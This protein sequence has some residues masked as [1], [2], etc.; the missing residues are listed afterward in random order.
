MSEGAAVVCLAATPADRAAIVALLRACDL[1]TADLPSSLEHFFVGQAGDRIVGVIGL[2][3]H[4]NRGLVRSLAVAPGHRGQR[5]ARALWHAALG[6][7]RDL[8][9]GDLF[10]LTATAEA[11][12]AHWG[13]VRVAREAAPDEIR[14]TEQFRSL[15]PA[16]AAVMRLAV[17]EAHE[18]LR[19]SS[20]LSV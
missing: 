19:P 14:Q 16:S 6:R 7:A 3:V 10:L 9:L 12:F 1:P 18:F 15:C 20:R 8:G 5:L 2:E 13:F 17:G 4:G 11:I